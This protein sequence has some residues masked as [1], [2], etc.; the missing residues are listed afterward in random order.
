MRMWCGC[1]VC[2]SC[3][4]SWARAALDGA[5]AALD[6]S[7]AAQPIITLTCPL[8]SAPLRACDAASVLKHDARLLDQYDLALRDAA[9]RGMGD[10]RPCPKCHGGGFVTWSCIRERRLAT[11]AW[12][13]LGGSLIIAVLLGVGS[14]GLLTTIATKCY[15]ALLCVAAVIQR[16]ARAGRRPF[17]AA[18]DRRRAIPRSTRRSSRSIAAAPTARAR[19]QSCYYIRSSTDL[20]GRARARCTRP[21]WRSRGRRR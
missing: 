21:R 6:T 7:G 2:T 18:S 15:P 19:S 8:C 5:G 14:G 17:V 12:A 4:S 13:H 10:F 3:C 1:T 16:A 20:R 9:L 11:R